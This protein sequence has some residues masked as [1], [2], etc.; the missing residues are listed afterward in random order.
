[1]KPG[2][3]TRTGKSITR[4]PGSRSRSVM[5]AKRPI[6]SDLYFDDLSVDSEKSADETLGA[7]IAIVS[8]DYCSDIK[9]DTRVS[10]SAPGF[11]SVTAKC[12]KQGARLRRPIPPSPTVALDA[13]GNGS[14]VFPADRYPH[15][16][17]TV[18]NHRRQR[19]AAAT[20]AT[21]SS[22]TRAA[23]RGTKGCPK[24]PPPAAKGMAL[25][26]AD[27][28]NGP[29]SISSTDP[30]A[31][32]LRSQAAERRQDFSTLPFTGHDAPN[33]PFTQVDTYLRIRA[34]A[35]KTQCRPDLLAEERRQRHQGRRCPATSSAGSSA[36]TPSAPGRPSG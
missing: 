26:F 5:T 32:L 28:F 34:D 11:K 25:V 13:S 10:L 12:W 24:T 31:T 14:F 27:D 36:P 22:T 23:C 3:G 16:P 29:L 15:G 1:M 20:T 2:A 21:S 9:G 30:K 8:P 17:I 18:T 7:Q 6:E 4:S 35:K 33:N 19:H